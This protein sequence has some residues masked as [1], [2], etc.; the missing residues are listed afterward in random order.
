MTSMGNSPCGGGLPQSS[1]LP[2]KVVGDPERVA[3]VEKV[4][5]EIRPFLAADGGNIQ[6]VGVEEGWVHVRLQGACM[7]CHA[8][9]MT[10]HQAIEPR[11]RE[12]CS[13]FEGVRAV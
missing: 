3:E 1:D 2:E 7:G 10:L 6:L 4:L 5:E 12:A 9:A 8:S 11:L 13:W